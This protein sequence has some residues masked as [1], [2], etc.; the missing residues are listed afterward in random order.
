MSYCRDEW[1]SDYTYRAVFEYRQATESSVQA[2]A[3]G[4]AVLVSGRITRAGIELDPVF[5][6][7][8]AAALPRGGPHRLTLRD[9]DGRPVYDVAFAGSRVADL[10]DGTDEHFAFAIP[11]AAL[12]GREAA[13][14][15]VTARGERAELRRP[16]A[17]SLRDDARA[18]ATR[19]PDGSVDVSWSDPAARGLIVRDARTGRIISI[20]RGASVRL[21]ADD[22]ELEVLASDGLRTRISRVRPAPF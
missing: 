8:T 1:I 9:A 15:T 19:A 13:S 22:R 5:T 7:T 4:A 20:V 6:V 21:P 14:L 16:A 12:G 11:L 2:G 10:G 3:T 18:V 17:A